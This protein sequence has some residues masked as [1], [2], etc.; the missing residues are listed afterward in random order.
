[1]P[2]NRSERRAMFRLGLVI[3]RRAWVSGKTFCKEE[4]A[5]VKVPKFHGRFRDL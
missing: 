1:M 5:Y 2:E 3:W 4:I